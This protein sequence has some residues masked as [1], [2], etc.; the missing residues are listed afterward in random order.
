MKSKKGRPQKRKFSFARLGR[1]MRSIGYF[2][3]LGYFGVAIS[4]LGPALPDLAELVS[5]DLGS[6]SALFSA[7]SIGILFGSLLAGWAFDKYAGHTFFAVSFLAL[8][9]TF[10]FQPLNRSYW[11]LVGMTTL[12]G[13][14]FGILGTGAST[15]IV[16]EHDDNPEPWVNTQSF[17][18]S[19]G[20]F[21]APLLLT[22]SY[23]RFA[24][25]DQAFWTLARAASVLATY[26]F[27]LNSPKIR[28]QAREH[29][30]REKD[31]APIVILVAM[32]FLIYVGVEVSLN[33]WI[34][35][36]ATLEYG[37]AADNARL[38]NSI[39]WGE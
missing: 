34:F 30:E 29:E 6:L 20:G 28:T 2:I 5:V 22:F 39:L 19:L 26:F 36:L 9:I 31:P 23:A 32:L 1:W 25:F 33:G 21:M 18:N 10:A 16:W 14:A 3:T 35:S 8:G 17:I 4:V 11:I 38:L 37:F 24:Q 27:F 15:F 13:L 7:R 12:Q